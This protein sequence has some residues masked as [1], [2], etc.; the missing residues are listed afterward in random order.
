MLTEK[1]LLDDFHLAGKKMGEFETAIKEI[2]QHTYHMVM[3]MRDLIVVS[4]IDNQYQPV[5]PAIAE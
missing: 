1:F 4:L 3:P 2:D 5:L